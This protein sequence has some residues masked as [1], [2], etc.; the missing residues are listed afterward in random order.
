MKLLRRLY[1]IALTIVLLALVLVAALIVFMGPIA[2]KA[3]ETFGPKVLG[4]SVE[5]REV[6]IAPLQGKVQVTGLRIG[7]PQ[8]YSDR[9]LVELGEF[10][11]DMDTRSLFG[12]GPTIVNMVVLSDLTVSY[13][14]LAGVSNVEALQKHMDRHKR[15][16]VERQ[17]RE[18]SR[19]VIIEHFDCRNGSVCYSAAF[20]AHQS[21]IVPLPEIDI[22]DIGKDAGGVTPSEASKRILGEIMSRVGRAVT[23]VS[24]SAVTFSGKVLNDTGNAVVD[25]LNAVGKG[26][27]RLFK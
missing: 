14:V 5:V 12:R 8:G 16:A 3:I 10:R 23:N 13:E 4:V 20:T 22:R 9:P 25:G 11:F 19:R 24:G 26:M 18:S 7:N 2:K 15:R 27:R 17:R 6:S 21:V 1:C